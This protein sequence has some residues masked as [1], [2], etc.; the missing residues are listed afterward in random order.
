MNRQV[1]FKQ[2]VTKLA[3]IASISA[4]HPMIIFRKLMNECVNNLNEWIP[5]LFT[6][7]VE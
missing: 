4:H 1:G 5:V 6:A 3:S 2:N 7:E